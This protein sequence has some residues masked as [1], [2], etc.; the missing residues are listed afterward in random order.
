MALFV[1]IERKDR[2]FS[3]PFFHHFALDLRVT[4]G[5]SG[6]VRRLPVAEAVGPTRDCG[7]V[8][9]NEFQRGQTQFVDDAR[10]RDSLVES[11]HFVV[12][13]TKLPPVPSAL[14]AGDVELTRCE[15]EVKVKVKVKDL[16]HAHLGSWPPRTAPFS[17][18]PSRSQPLFRPGQDSCRSWTLSAFPGHRSQSKPSSCLRTTQSSRHSL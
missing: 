14:V 18:H 4:S 3:H 7:G 2:W 17:C 13:G 6:A 11:D 15:S 8:T 10:G 1:R 9:A 12:E 5:A 16:K